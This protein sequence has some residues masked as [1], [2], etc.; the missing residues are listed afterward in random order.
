MSTNRP[1]RPFPPP[2]TAESSK[3]PSAF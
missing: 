2:S 1:S 3:R